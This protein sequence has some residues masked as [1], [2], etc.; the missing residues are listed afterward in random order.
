MQ[1][2][3]VNIKTKKDIYKKP[4]WLLNVENKIENMSDEELDELFEITYSKL[5]KGGLREALSI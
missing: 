2:R 1:K 5:K 4:A 3:V